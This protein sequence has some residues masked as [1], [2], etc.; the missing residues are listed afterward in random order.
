MPVAGS[1]VAEHQQLFS[2]HKVDTETATLTEM[3]NTEIAVCPEK[4]LRK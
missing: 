4:R 2:Q 1:G 3:E